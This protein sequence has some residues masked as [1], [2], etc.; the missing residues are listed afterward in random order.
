[1]VRL[2]CFKDEEQ[3]GDLLISMGRFDTALKCIGKCKTSHFL[4]SALQNGKILYSLF[5]F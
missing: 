4:Y 2:G 3:V 5:I 1:M